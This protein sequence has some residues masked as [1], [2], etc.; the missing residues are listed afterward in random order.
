MTSERLLAASAVLLV[1][2][3]CSKS[4]APTPSRL[5]QPAPSFDLS[6]VMKQVHF[7]YREEAPGQF[8]GGHSSYAVQVDDGAISFRPIASGH[9]SQ[10]VSFAN[11][12]V[13]HSGGELGALSG[14]KLTD[15]G[16]L[17]LRAVRRRRR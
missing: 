5:E 15:K 16:T 3:G 12:R 11:A 13:L 14:G 17:E 9:D 1:A 7:A 4:P 6:A 8:S 2:L 10:A